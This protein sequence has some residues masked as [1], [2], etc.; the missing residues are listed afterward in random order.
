MIASVSERSRPA[1][2]LV[3]ALVFATTGSCERFE[4]TYPSIADAQADGAVERGWIPRSLP[5]SAQDI[6]EWHDL[7]SNRVFGKLRYEPADDAWIDRNLEP[8][9][10]TAQVEVRRQWG[11]PEWWPDQLCG[12]LDVSAVQAQHIVVLTADGFMFARDARSQM[13]YFW[14]QRRPT[15]AFNGARASGPCP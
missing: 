13:L 8:V 7:D 6:R 10:A 12:R 15:S 1:L 11:D 3:L 2:A 9:S 14:L 5:P 4:S